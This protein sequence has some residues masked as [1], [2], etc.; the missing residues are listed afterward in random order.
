MRRSESQPGTVLRR[1]FPLFNQVPISV[2]SGLEQVYKAIGSVQLSRGAVESSILPRSAVEVYLDSY[3]CLE[4]AQ[5]TV[6]Q[7]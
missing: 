5:T 7:C 1:S 6:K 4:Y 2:S 3:P